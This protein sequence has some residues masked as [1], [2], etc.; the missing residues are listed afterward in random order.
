MATATAPSDTTHA[1]ALDLLRA[2]TAP[3]FVAEATGLSVSEAIALAEINGLTPGAP[4]PVAHTPVVLPRQRQASQPS[5]APAG[6]PPATGKAP[7]SRIASVSALLAWALAHDDKKVRADGERVRDLLETLHGRQAADQ[8]IT[9]LAAEIATIE[10]RRQELADRLAALQP[11]S[12]KKKRTTDHD[13][14][15]VRA[16]AAANNIEVNR[17]GSVPRSVVAAWREA[18]GA[19]E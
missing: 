10:Q 15:E 18:T 5:P 11:Q 7:G 1:T 2:G 6:E 19:D 8:E 13:P 12:A 17:I 9:A 3:K 4:T 14:K 16:W